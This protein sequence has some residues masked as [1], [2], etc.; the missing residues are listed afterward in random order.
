MRRKILLL[1]AAL[2]LLLPVVAGAHYLSRVMGI[3]T[4]EECAEKFP[5]MESSP[6]QCRAGWKSF[7]ESVPEEVEEG[8]IRV[9]SPRSGDI[10]SFPLTLKGEAR[11]FEGT[12]QYRLLDTNEALLAQGFTTAAVTDIGSFGPFAIDITYPQPSGG[13]GILE[14]FEESAEDGSVQNLVR[15]PLH[16]PERSISTINV[17]FSN[18]YEDPGALQCDV[19]F[20]TERY[21]LG[22]EDLARRAL[23]E[24]LAGP[25]ELE[26]I[27]GFRTSINPGTRLIEFTLDNGVATANFDATLQH[28]LGGSCRVMAIR[29]QMTET[30][31]QFPEIRDVVIAVEGETE[32]VLQP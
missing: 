9:T 8:N 30:L 14:V 27:A 26:N 17:F 1:L 6:R 15:I 13:Q 10:A 7:T 31:K 32:E 20:P 11:V 5:V 2:L 18:E 4:F 16:F 12:V 24:L 19:V 23:E 3:Q 22:N 25:S 29:S 21:M 28:E